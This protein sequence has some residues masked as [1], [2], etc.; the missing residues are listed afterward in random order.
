MALLHEHFQLENPFRSDFFLKSRFFKNLNN[1][2][3]CN[4]NRAFTLI[5]K[6][7]ASP[8]FRS[9]FEHLTER[10]LPRACPETS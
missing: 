2:S 9:V 10:V 5:S 6:N 1:I 3:S 7:K 8:S 4:H